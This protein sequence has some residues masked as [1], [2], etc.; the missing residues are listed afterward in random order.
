LQWIFP[1]ILLVGLPF[2]P[3]SPWYLVRHDRPEDA[4]AVIVRLGGPGVDADLHLRQILDTVEL[5]DSQAASTTY[6]DCFRG[7]NRRRTI[8]ALMVFI[9]QQIAGVVFVLGFSNYFFQLAGFDTA[10]S[11]RLGVGVT[12][13]GVVGNLISLFTVNS[14]GRR[15]LFFW[16][17]IGC[18]VVNLI[19]GLSSLPNT[20]AGR[21]SMAIFV[22]HLSRTNDGWLITDDRVQLCLSDRHWATGIRHILRSWQREA[23][24]E[25]RRHWHLRE[26]DLRLHREHRHPVSP[27]R[28]TDA[29]ADAA[30]YLVN[31]DEADLGGKVG[32]IFGGLGLLGAAWTWVFIPETKNRTIDEWVFAHMLRSQRSCQIGRALR[33]ANTAKKVREDRC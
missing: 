25:D 6:V 12:A 1:V 10:K 33:S 31:P 14:F 9:L 23:A 26:P 27:T 16:G 21:W 13:I 28:N 17:M 22:G 32:F 29:L 2:A 19:V 8:I 18:A 15:P 11:F 4:H 3:E 20:S 7:T 24:V 5:E 30:R